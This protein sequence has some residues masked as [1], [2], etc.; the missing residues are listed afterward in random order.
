MFIP[1]SKFYGNNG[2]ILTLHAYDSCKNTVFL[3]AKSARA[4]IFKLRKEI[5]AVGSQLCPP[6][7]KK[8][9]KTNNYFL[10]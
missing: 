4:D 9:L 10:Q 3:R 5:L 6:K 2:G 1:H 8:F 7:M